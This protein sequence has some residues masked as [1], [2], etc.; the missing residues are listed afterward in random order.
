MN[1]I[2]TLGILLKDLRASEFCSL[3]QNLREQL[4]GHSRTS[5]FY[6]TVNVFLILKKRT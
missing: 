2:L 4:S 5:K 3:V 6:T 1:I